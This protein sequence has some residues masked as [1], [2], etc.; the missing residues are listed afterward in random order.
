MHMNSTVKTKCYPLKEHLIVRVFRTTTSINP[1]FFLYTKEVRMIVYSFRDHN[2]EF[3]LTCASLIWPEIATELY[4]KKMDLT[5]FTFSIYCIN[6]K[7][8]TKIAKSLKSVL[9]GKSLNWIFIF[10]KLIIWN[11]LHVP[12]LK[13]LFKSV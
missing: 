1:F 11:L 5:F 4:F 6:S 12:P 8:F 10:V 7:L 2:L 9:L 13:S 3:I